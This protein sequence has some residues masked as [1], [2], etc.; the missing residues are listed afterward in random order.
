[1]IDAVNQFNNAFVR[2]IRTPVLHRRTFGGVPR[3]DMLRTKAFSGAQGACPPM[4]GDR[5]P[6][7]Q[8][9]GLFFFANY[10][11][12]CATRPWPETAEKE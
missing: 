4:L 9:L 1:M 2:K 6:G 11:R 7:G 10:E 5:I 3:F 8:I 12:S